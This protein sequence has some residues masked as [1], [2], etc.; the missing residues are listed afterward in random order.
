MQIHPTTY[1]TFPAFRLSAGEW[2]AIC[3]PGLGGNVPEFT[4]RATGRQWLWV[5]PQV[6]PAPHDYGCPYGWGSATGIDECFP[7]IAEGVYPLEPYRGVVIPDH[8][9]AWALP[10]ATEERDGKLVMTLDGPRL[11]YRLERTLSETPDGAGLLFSYRLANLGDAPLTYCW[12]SH[13]VCAA[14]PGMHILAPEDAHFRVEGSRTWRFGA[15]DTRRAWHLPGAEN[16][17]PIVPCDPQTAKHLGDKLFLVNVTR[18]WVALYHPETDSH[19]RFGYDLNEIDTV[20]VW[21]NLCDTEGRDHVAI[22]P[23]IGTYDSLEASL[24]AG[25]ARTLPARA[26]HNWSWSLT[27]GAGSP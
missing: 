14:S 17:S 24:A 20:G 2:E 16:P 15:V 1:A 10:W 22:E 12:S 6:P 13:P 26:E 3:L 8:G 5:N 11:P 4:D 7:A 18:D 23:C 25:S 19:L 9:D 27:P 21:M